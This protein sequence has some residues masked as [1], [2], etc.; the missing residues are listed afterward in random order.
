ML[1]LYRVLFQIT[2]VN[3]LKK[4]KLFIHHFLRNDHLL[5]V[6]SILPNKLFKSVSD[7]E[8]LVVIFGVLL[9]QK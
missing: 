3:S 9:K 6:T 5:H 2:G 8:N 7:L 4:T 1:Q